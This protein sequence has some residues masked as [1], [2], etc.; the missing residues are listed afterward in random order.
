MGHGDRTAPVTLPRCAPVA[1]TV[2][3]AALT[4]VATL[5]HGDGLRLGL[6]GLQPVERAGIHVRA[7]ADVGLFA[8]WAIFTVGAGDHADHGQVVLAC[9]FEVAL[10]VPRTAEDRAGAIV[11]EDEVGDEQRKGL[12]MEG[13][14]LHAQA[15]VE[16]LLLLR[17]QLGL[18]RTG[19]L[20]FADEFGQLGVISSEFAGQRV[21]GRH[22]KE[23]R[24]V[25]GIWAGGKDHQLVVATL[26]GQRH[27]GAFGPADPVFLHQ[28][29]LVRPAIQIVVD[30]V[31]QLRGVVGDL[32]EPLGQLPLFHQ[33]AGAP[34][35]AVLDLLVGQHGHLDRVPVDPAFLLV[36]QPLAIHLD[37][38]ALLLLIVL[39]VAGGE[40]TG[41]VD[42]QAHGFQLG[43]HQVDVAV[44]PVGRVYLALKGCVLRGQPEGIPTDRMQHIVAPRALVPRYNVTQRVVANVA[45][46]DRTR[47]V[48]KHLQHVVLFTAGIGF[49]AKGLLLIP[50]GLPLLLSGGGVIAVGAHGSVPI[51]WRSMMAAILAAGAAGWKGLGPAGSYAAPAAAN[52]CDVSVLVAAQFRLI[53]SCWAARRIWPSSSRAAGRD[54]GALRHIP[55]SWI[56]R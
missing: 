52:L 36:D 14:V 35:A 13:R 55:C 11:H 42:R 53:F 51:M 50:D 38:H 7:V 49:G 18:R 19:A 56:C 9:E 44:G 54:D 45:H 10:I 20:A 21:L 25:N 37:E 39:G 22:G 3:D 43:P 41:P 30:G 17:F 16:A 2:G 29:H 32:E 6:V 46:V 12:I 5:Q 40:F 1:Q 24:A 4:L 28:P 31:Q 33:R 27:F 23:R 48:G 47:G 26:D 15:G 8:D 34:A